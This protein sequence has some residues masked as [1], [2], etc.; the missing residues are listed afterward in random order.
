MRREPSAGAPYLVAHRAGNEPATLRRAATI[1]ADLIEA[2]VRYHRGQMEVRH[3]KT[4]G[5]IP[6]LWDKWLLAPG[7][8]PRFLLEDLLPLVPGDVELML[9]IKPGRSHYP[10][11]VREAMREALPG[12]A[13]TVCSQFWDLLAPF[14]DEPHVRVVHSI[15]STRLL[16]AVVPHL[17]RHRSDAVSIHKK[18]LNPA[19]VVAL[20]RHVSLIMTWPVND[21]AELRRLESWGVNGFIIDDLALLAKLAAERAATTPAAST[22]DT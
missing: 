9:D 15:G 3:R 19:S 22:P 10:G 17:E 6:L 8:T 4:M 7:W 16:R 13:Y 21:E 11:L 12:R 14:H 1:G 18:L 2:D 5:P 20:R